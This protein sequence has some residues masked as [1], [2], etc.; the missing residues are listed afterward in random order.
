[1]KHKQAWLVLGLMCALVG[2][3]STADDCSKQADGLG[4][5]YAIAEEGKGG[6]PRLLSLLRDTRPRIRLAAIKTCELMGAEAAGALEALRDLVDDRDPRV[7][8]RARYCIFH[9]HFASVE[10]LPVVVAALR[11]PDVWLRRAACLRLGAFGRRATGYLSEA[12]R[13]RDPWVREAAVSTVLSQVAEAWH[14]VVGN[15][16]DPEPSVRYATAALLVVAHR[17]GVV[18][19]E[20]VVGRAADVLVDLI[21]EEPCW[22]KASAVALGRFPVLPA[23]VRARLRAL[24]DASDSSVAGIAREVLAAFRN[25][26]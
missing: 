7:A 12:A 6:V 20:D 22:R 9:L 16:D 15:L 10:S 18:T 14:L 13:D 3:A 1:M 19:E 23:Q 17:D 21:V 4:E 5:V 25:R 2:C 26:G 24:A 11:S 8:E